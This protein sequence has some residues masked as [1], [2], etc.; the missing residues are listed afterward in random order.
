MPLSYGIPK[1]IT[2]A[3]GN[4]KGIAALQIVGSEDRWNGILD[5]FVLA[6]GHAVAFAVALL[7]NTADVVF[8]PAS[9]IVMYLL[10]SK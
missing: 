3:G 4:S 6:G 1:I 7:E 8:M 2:Q 5:I 9:S 10:N